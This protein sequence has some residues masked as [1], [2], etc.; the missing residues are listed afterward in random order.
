ML[1]AQLE[2][3]EYSA[4]VSAAGGTGT[5]RRVDM[6]PSLLDKVVRSEGDF[7]SQRLR[8]IFARSA[9]WPL[10]S[11]VGSPPRE[12]RICPAMV[13]FWLE[14]HREAKPAAR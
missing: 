8:K 4:G 1:P 11:S 12:L 3:E 10:Q 6:L 9:A 7:P 2:I 14:L 13:C 5:Q